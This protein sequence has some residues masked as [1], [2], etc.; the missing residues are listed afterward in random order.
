ML[1]PVF[2]YLSPGLILRFC[3]RFAK[4][5]GLTIW[6]VILPSVVAAEEENPVAADA[7]NPFEIQSAG[8]SLDDTLL[9]LDLKIRIDLPEFVGIAVNQGFAV[10]LMFEVEIYTSRNNWFDK[11]IV[12]LK[13]SYQLLFLPMLSSYVVN[14]VN[15]G[16]RH[17]FDSLDE[18][19]EYMEVVYNYPMLDIS[20]FDFNRE[21]YAR[22]RFRIDN[23]ALP[24]PLKPSIFWPSDWDERSS[25]Y[26][27]EMISLNSG[28]S[29]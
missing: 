16:K 5:A 17:Y 10:P 14:D 11:R 24:L 27:F 26:S 8:F 15:A 21:F 12:T 20:N 1:I 2:Q 6:L 7:E 19:V 28:L 22:T 23:D 29:G 18:A 3:V 25:W 9:K 13:Q 4:I